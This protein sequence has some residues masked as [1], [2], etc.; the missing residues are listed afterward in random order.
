MVAKRTEL[1]VTVETRG[2]D[3]VRELVA[4]LADAGFK[5]RV[6]EGADA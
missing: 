6:L 5:V 4:A 3:H 2:P 1:D